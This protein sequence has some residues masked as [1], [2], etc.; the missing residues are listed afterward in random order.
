MKA[1]NKLV[2]SDLH[3]SS[4]ANPDLMKPTPSN[5]SAEAKAEQKFDQKQWISSEENRKV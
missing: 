2:W 4:M 5:L 1:E 3:L